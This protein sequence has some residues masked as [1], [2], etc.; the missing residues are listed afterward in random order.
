MQQTKTTFTFY[1]Y[2]ILFFFK[3]R[4][5]MRTHMPEFKNAI[6]LNGEHKTITQIYKWENKTL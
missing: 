6:S 3:K 1:S 5:K 2:S 4:S